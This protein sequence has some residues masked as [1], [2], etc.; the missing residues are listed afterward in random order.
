MVK[1]ERNHLKGNINIL[2]VIKPSTNKTTKYLNI[3]IKRETNKR[4]KELKRFRYTACCYW[5]YSS[6]SHRFGFPVL[7]SNLAVSIP[8]DCLLHRLSVLPLGFLYSVV[9]FLCSPP[10]RVTG[11]GFLYSSPSR[12]TDLGFLSYLV[13][14]TAPIQPRSFHSFRLTASYIVRPTTFGE[15]G[16]F[17]LSL[18]ELVL[19]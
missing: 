5:Y 6:S 2:V 17:I 8:L 14:P 11:L 1:Y 19:N 18:Q 12:I 10:S 13:F 3:Y 16:E 7:R 9:G 4:N 15:L